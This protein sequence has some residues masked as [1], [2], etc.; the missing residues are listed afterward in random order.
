MI[1]CAIKAFAIGVEPS[2]NTSDIDKAVMW[3][4]LPSPTPHPDTV[5]LKEYEEQLEVFKKQLEESQKENREKGEILNKLN[6]K[7]ITT[8]NSINKCLGGVLK[9]KGEVFWLAC[10]NNKF[11]DVQ[12]MAI[13]LSSISIH[14]TSTSK[15]VGTSPVSN[16]LKNIAGIN[17]DGNP[18]ITHKGRYRVFKDID[19]SIYNLAYIIKNYYVKAGRTTIASIGNKF[20]P[21]DDAENGKYGMQNETWI[22]NVTRLF[23][24]ISK[25]C[26]K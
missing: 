19:E 20:C 7:K 21:L 2:P 25:D 4:T 1:I 12:K 9:N 22:P 8:I 11:E 14:E 18:K 6:A 5:K 23:N 17:W 3:S 10:E 13:M 26:L 16:D 24:K 15:G